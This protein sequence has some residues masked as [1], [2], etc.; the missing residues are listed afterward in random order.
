MERPLTTVG[1]LIRNPDGHVLLIRTHKWRDR[2]GVPGGKLE[3]GESLADALNREVHEETGLNLTCSYWGPVQEAVNSPE[4][5]RDAHF[6]L[7]NFVSLTDDTHV[8][9]NDE[10]Q[11]H[12]WAAPEDALEL[13]LNTP[14]R[15]LLEFYLANLPLETHLTCL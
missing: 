12:V 15:V 7:L 9:L 4:F 3:Y 11:T 1:A 14:T 5:Y 10:A 2:W 13:D 6:I 8:T